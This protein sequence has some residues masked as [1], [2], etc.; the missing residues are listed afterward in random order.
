MTLGDADNRSLLLGGEESKEATV[1]TPSVLPLHHFERGSSS[2]RPLQLSHASD[3]TH[4]ALGLGVPDAVQRERF[5]LCPVKPELLS[6][7][8]AMSPGL[9][10]IRR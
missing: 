9:F 6:L 7:P 1:F 3:S 2:A 4:F 5:S 8:C 10:L